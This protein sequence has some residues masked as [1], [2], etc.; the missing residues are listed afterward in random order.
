MSDR[1]DRFRSLVRRATDGARSVASVGNPVERV[2]RVWSE[3][4]ER[5]VRVPE[6]VLAK[7]VLHA[8]RI[9]A[10]SVRARAGRLEIMVE[11]DTGRAVTAVLVPAG[12]SFAPRG[13]KEIALEAQPASAANEAVVREI[14]GIVGSVVARTLW[15]PFL[16]GLSKRPDDA[17]LVDRDG[18]VLRIDLRSCPAIR[19][20]QS[21][22][23]AN[24]MLLDLI[25]I[26]KLD[27]DEQGISIQLGLAG[28]LPR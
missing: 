8:S 19:A 17:G 12:V 28:V 18:A 24:A 13:A 27:F 9:S 6:R 20:A 16:P 3:L 22:A 2:R 25:G 4:R 26:D 14:A 5:R 11:L 10:A 21:A 23:P 15:S 7:A 1:L